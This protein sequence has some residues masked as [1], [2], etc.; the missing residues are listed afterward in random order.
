LRYNIHSSSTELTT[1]DGWWNI[2]VMTKEQQEL[3]SNYRRGIHDRVAEFRRGLN[4][5]LYNMCIQYGGH[6]FY[7]WQTR[8]IDGT[9]GPIKKVS[10]VC[11]Y[12]WYEEH[13]K[14]EDI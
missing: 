9:F 1:G 6:S 12:C 2:L 10:R 14:S 4:D 13:K 7:D 11:K 8:W 5:E 3:V